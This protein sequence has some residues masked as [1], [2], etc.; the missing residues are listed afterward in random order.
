MIMTSQLSENSHRGFEGIKAALYLGSTGVKSNTAVEMQLRL[1]STRTGSRSSGKERDAETGLDFFLARYYSA[2]QGRFLSPDEFKGGIVDPF[3]G[4]DI[5]QP[6]PIPY[7]DINHPQT[8]NKYGYVRNNPLRYIDPD[9][10]MDEEHHTSVTTEAAKEAG[11]SIKTAQLMVDANLRVDAK[12]N[13]FNNPAHGMTDVLMPDYFGKKII[14]AVIDGHLDKA[15]QAATSGNYKGAVKELG[16]GTHT[17]QDYKTHNLVT[18]PGHLGEKKYN[19]PEMNKAAGE[20][21]KE[22]LL[23]FKNTL[24][25]KLGQEQSNEILKRLKKAGEQ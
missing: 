23:K 4:K 9:G 17:V 8:L 13:F 5:S 14:S 3:T 20:A 11:Y 2:A 22:Y 6:G 10:H 25:K 24:I 15:V 19:T 21:T 16:F 7:S 1:R 18:L 12:L